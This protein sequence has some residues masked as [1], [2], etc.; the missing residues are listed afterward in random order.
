MRSGKNQE[1]PLKNWQTG[2]FLSPCGSSR[3]PKAGNGFFRS[4]IKNFSQEPLQFFQIVQAEVHELKRASIFP[5][6]ILESFEPDNLAEGFE[7][8]QFIVKIVENL[9]AEGLAGLYFFREAQQD[10]AFAYV[11]RMANA[12]FRRSGGKIFRWQ[13]QGNSGMNPSFGQDGNQIRHQP[14]FSYSQV[15]HGPFHLAFLAMPPSLLQ[16]ESRSE[17]NA[18]IDSKTRLSFPSPPHHRGGKKR[19]PLSILPEHSEF[20]AL[21]YPLKTQ[22]ILKSTLKIQ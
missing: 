1:E 11:D 18:R 22:I 14:F 3:F 15:L 8:C 17:A 12:A 19:L 16:E 10:P 20:R 9:D 7:A 4:S 13:P 21:I 5:V 6:G 2:G